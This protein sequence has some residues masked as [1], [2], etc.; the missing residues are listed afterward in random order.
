[1]TERTLMGLSEQKLEPMIDDIT[2]PII[3]NML[4]SPKVD[5]RILD[6]EVKHDEPSFIKKSKRRK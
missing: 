2:D 5:I 1:M 3:N 4:L 6:Q